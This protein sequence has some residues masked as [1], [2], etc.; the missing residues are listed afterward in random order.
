MGSLNTYAIST[1]YEKL[2]AGTMEW[3]ECVFFKG[4]H[5]FSSLLK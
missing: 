5:N 2:D 4:V 1:V 3:R